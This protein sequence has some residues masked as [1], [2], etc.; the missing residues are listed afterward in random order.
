MLAVDV[1][2]DPTFKAGK[3]RL[4]FEGE[5]QAGT[6]LRNFD[7]APDGRRFL[8]TRNIERPRAPLTQMIVVLN[9][10]EELKRRAAAARQIAAG[11]RNQG[12]VPA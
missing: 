7:V 5:Y 2:L 1:S 9:W 4:L 12:I 11:L 8:M 10:F 6:P 3:P